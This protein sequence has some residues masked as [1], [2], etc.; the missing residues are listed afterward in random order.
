MK[1]NLA[2]DVGRRWAGELDAHRSR[3]M[4]RIEAQ[5][6]RAQ[7]VQERDGELTARRRD[8]ETIRNNKWQAAINLAAELESTRRQNL[9]A[10]FAVLNERCQQSLAQRDQA[11]DAKCQQLREHFQKVND[12][13]EWKRKNESLKAWEKAE[14]LQQMMKRSD[15]HQ[16]ALLH[17]DG[18]TEWSLAI[19]A[20]WN[21]SARGGLM[22]LGGDGLRQGP[23]QDCTMTR[24]AWRVASSM[25]KPHV[26]GPWPGGSSGAHDEQAREQPM[27]RV[28]GRLEGLSA[29]EGSG[30]SSG[31]PEQAARAAEVLEG[32]QFCDDSSRSDSCERGGVASGG[33]RPQGAQREGSSPAAGA[34]PAWGASAAAPSQEGESSSSWAPAGRPGGAAAG[35][36]APV[37]PRE[38]HDSGQCKPCRY[39]V[40]RRSCPEKDACQF[41]HLEHDT[42]RRLRPCSS[43]RDK[44]KSMA[45]RLA[46]MDDGVMDRM[47]EI[48]ERSSLQGSYM[49][50]IMAS[51]LTSRGGEPPEQDD[52]RYESAERFA[53]SSAA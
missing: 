22:T 53:K 51:R 33:G 30:S 6:M 18:E 49:R 14:W 10:H 29:S 13:A 28:W 25:S 7:R 19:L 45:D 41:C 48:S 20:A 39:F 38:L 34:Q 9:Q 46:S 40:K 21:V 17:T 26:D 37:C 47:D 11:R 4:E 2:S 24:P 16:E 1:K 5:E 23:H 35:A 12:T 44:C 43:K 15:E 32:V 3:Q 50:S 42:V 31:P 36:A 8:R 27:H 52:S